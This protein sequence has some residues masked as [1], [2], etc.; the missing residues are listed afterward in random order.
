MNISLMAHTVNANQHVH[1][2]KHPMFCSGYAALTPLKVPNAE[3]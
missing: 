3:E 1:Q 2:S